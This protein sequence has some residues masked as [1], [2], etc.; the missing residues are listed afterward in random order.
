[1]ASPGVGPAE[2]SAK[3]G[4]ES[5]WPQPRGPRGLGAGAGAGGAAAGGGAG[6]AAAGGSA[7]PQDGRR[8]G[9]GAAAGAAARAPQGPDEGGAAG[10]GA[11]LLAGA[12]AEAACKPASTCAEINQC[13]GRTRQFFTKSF[14]AM[15]RP[16]WLRRA[17]RN[18]HRQAIEQASR[19]WRGGRRERAVMF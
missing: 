8:A 3:D 15:T 11:P 13:V 6:G 12:G 17:V 14:S 10:G 16:C 19:R 4:F 2:A 18:E 9:D 5:T 7:A 1:M